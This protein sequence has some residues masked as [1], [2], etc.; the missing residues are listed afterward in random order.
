MMLVTVAKYICMV[1]YSFALWPTASGRGVQRLGVL[2]YMFSCWYQQ[3]AARKVSPT[4][5]LI[6]L[7]CP[8]FKCGHHFV[9]FAFVLL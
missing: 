6:S 3:A 5:L 7:S 9:A 2:W 4:L 8:A 1:L